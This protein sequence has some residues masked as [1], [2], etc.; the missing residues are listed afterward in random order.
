MAASEDRLKELAKREE[1]L[2]RE[3]TA[4]R[5]EKVSTA[6]DPPWLPFHGFLGCCV[7]ALVCFIS[8]V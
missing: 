6:I 1:E 3:D 2:R 4:L 7:V 5:Q 8:F